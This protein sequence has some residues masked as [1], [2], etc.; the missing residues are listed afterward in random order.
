MPDTKSVLVTEYRLW[1][2]ITQPVS[3]FDSSWASLFKERAFGNLASG[4]TTLSLVVWAPL[5]F[6][7]PS[8]TS[9]FFIED[10]CCAQHFPIM[11]GFGS[12]RVAMGMSQCPDSFS[13][14]MTSSWKQQLEAQLNQECLEVMWT[15]H[16]F[17]LSC[18]DFVG[19]V[20]AASNYMKYWRI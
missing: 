8:L 5:L 13:E 17:P 16:K 14:E 12:L 2:M 20:H 1:T 6:P 18:V 10:N 15:L 19:F 11:T 9:Q 4:M 7:C 3:R